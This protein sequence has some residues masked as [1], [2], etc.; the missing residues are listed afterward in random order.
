MSNNGFNIPVVLLLFKRKDAALKIIDRFRSVSVRKLYIL[1][2][3]GRDDN[4]IEMVRETREAVESAIDWDCE[5]IK[6]Y[7]EFNRGVFGNIALGA[8]WVFER[9]KWA[10][11]LEDD[12]LPELTF[13]DY[14]EELLKL[15]END[16]RILWICGTNYL[17]KYNPDNDVSYM[18]TKHMLPCGWASWSDKFIQY[19]DGYVNLLNDKYTEQRFIKDFPSKDMSE[20]YMRPLRIYRKQIEVGKQPSSWDYQMCLSVRANSMFGISP[21]YNQIKNI[22]VDEMSEHGG[23]SFSKVMT[24]RFCGMDSYPLIMPLKHPISVMTDL[25][26]EALINKIVTP[27]VSKLIRQ[28][29]SGTVKKILGKDPSDPL[30]RKN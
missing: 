29:I 26:Y 23:N 24:R 19:Y 7:A 27:P 3:Q 20:V 8:K 21:V 6:N 28:K 2:D 12:N 9:E 10:I 16:N 4:E 15:Y 5:V 13:F 14:C 30:F 11:F 22:G 25:K 17:G 18:F 1:A